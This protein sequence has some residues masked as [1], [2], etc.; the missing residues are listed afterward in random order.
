MLLP[1]TAAVVA[2]GRGQAVLAGVCLAAGLPVQADG[3]H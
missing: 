2:A 3:R 1:M